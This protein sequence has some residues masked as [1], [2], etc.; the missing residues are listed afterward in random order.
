VHNTVFPSLV[1]RELK[2]AGAEISYFFVVLA[3]VSLFLVVVKKSI[4]TLA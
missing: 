2:K 1:K 3:G 4:I